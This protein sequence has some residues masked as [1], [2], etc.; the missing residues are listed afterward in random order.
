[1]STLKFLEKISII[2]G[3]PYVRPPDDVL[4]TVFKQA[5]EKTSPIPIKIKINGATASINDR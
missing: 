4:L 3:N 5:E 1:M 2:N